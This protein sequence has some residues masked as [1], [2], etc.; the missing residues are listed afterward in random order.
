MKQMMEH[1]S[2][3][4]VTERVKTIDHHIDW[5]EA[6]LRDK[7]NACFKSEVPQAIKADERSANLNRA[8]IITPSIDLQSTSFSRVIEYHQRLQ[9]WF[10][11][12]TKPRSGGGVG[13]AGVGRRQC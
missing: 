10:M 2:S 8:E 3:S 5:H 13:V 4:L 6:Q 11:T 9:T 12:L 1:Q 7:D